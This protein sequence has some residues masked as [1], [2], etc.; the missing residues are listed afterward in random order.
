MTPSPL[1][2]A[3]TQA[4]WFVA[5]VGLLVFLSF[6]TLDLQWAKFLAQTDP[7]GNGPTLHVRSGDPAWDKE[8]ERRFYHWANRPLLADAGHRLTFGGHLRLALRN[9]AINGEALL[10]EATN[11][12]YQRQDLNQPTFCLRH[13]DP[14]RLQSPYPMAWG[15]F[16]DGIALDDNGAPVKYR[17]LKHH[18][19]DMRNIGNYWEADEV[20]ARYVRHLFLMDESDQFR[21]FPLI[22]PALRMFADLRRFEAATVAAAEEAANVAGMLESNT[23]DVPVDQYEAG[24]S[25]QIPQRSMVVAPRGYKFNQVEAKHPNSQYGS[26]RKEII[27]EVARCLT[28]PFIVA[29]GNSEGSSYASG[30]LDWQDFYKELAIIQGDFLEPLACDPTVDAFALELVLMGPAKGG[31]PKPPKWPLEKRWY[32]NTLQHVDPQKEANAVNVSLINGTT[33]LARE[34]A[35]QGLDWEAQLEQ[36]AAIREKMQALNA[37]HKLEGAFAI[38]PVTSPKGGAAAP[39]EPPAQT[40]AAGDPKGDTETTDDTEEGAK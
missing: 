22:A 40:P 2:R 13:I 25:W 3:R 19:Y 31:M 29:Y 37:K 21:G 33:N 8:F 26:F 10:V 15:E 34:L 1:L 17:I 32:W 5:G 6:W 27:G 20:D 38:Q 39:A 18:P 30:R 23:D 24:E 7:M 12:L 16:R 11:R 14:L 9:I 36:E 35:K 28:M 4:S